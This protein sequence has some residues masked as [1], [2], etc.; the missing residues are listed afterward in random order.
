MRIKARYILLLLP[1]L[2]FILLLGTNKPGQSQGDG[3]LLVAQVQSGDLNVSIHTVGRLDAAKSHMLS[4]KIRGNDGKIIFLVRDGSWVEKGDVLVKLDP[5]PFEEAV[6]S[7]QGTVDSLAAAVDA[8][9]QMLA[10]EKNQVAQNISAREYDLKVA[11]LDLQR[12][13]KGDGPLQLAQYREEMSKAKAEHER[14]LSF[15]EELIKLKKQGFENPSELTRAKE[16]A[17]TYGEKFKAAHQRFVSYRDYVLPSKVESAKAKVE[18]SRVIMGQ[19]KTAAVYKTANAAAD[20]KQVL[21]KKATAESSLAL[22]RQDLE[23][24]VLKAPFNGIAILYEA[25]RGG[26][27]RKPREGDNVLMHQPILYLPDISSL[28][29]RT[30]V[31]E[32]DLY[33]V[34]IGQQA[35]VRIDAYPSLNFKAEVKFIGSLATND[36]PRQSGKYFQVVLALTGKDRRLRPGMTARVHIRAENAEDVLLLPV[37][38]VF[39]DDEG[40][41]FCYVKAGG[42][43]EKRAVVTGRENGLQVEILSGLEKGTRVSTTAPPSQTNR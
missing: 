24:T 14:Y 41:S 16:N 21:A 20:Y 8:S 43:L 40:G 13:V 2:L 7:L 34:K 3:E 26:M 6:R 10:W 25:F 37:Q 39:P 28:I 36:N 9:K 23:N 42:R 33:K 12:L 17:D 27:K 29:V 35:S 5:S 18:N 22:A 30:R 31:R 38:A 11:E 1:V 19:T 4:S 32:V 15:Y